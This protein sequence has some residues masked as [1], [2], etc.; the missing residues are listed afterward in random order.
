MVALQSTGILSKIDN[1]CNFQYLC[2]ESGTI[3]LAYLKHGNNRKTGHF[4]EWAINTDP[5]S[6]GHD[7]TII[8]DVIW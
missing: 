8:K 6:T 2:I 4:Y 1:D 3:C 7:P 5:A